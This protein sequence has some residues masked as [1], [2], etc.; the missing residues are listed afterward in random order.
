MRIYHVLHL[1]IKVE[2]DEKKNETYII[3]DEAK[4]NRTQY[5][6]KLKIPQLKQSTVKNTYQTQFPLVKISLKIPNDQNV[7]QK[8]LDINLVTLLVFPQTILS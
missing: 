6:Q 3:N 2:P 1:E 5:G 7:F 4:E 8:P